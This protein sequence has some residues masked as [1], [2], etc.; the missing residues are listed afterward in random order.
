MENISRQPYTVQLETAEVQREPLTHPKDTQL[1]K[2]G[3]RLENKFPNARGQSN[4]T[5]YLPTSLRPH[6]APAHQP[7]PPKKHLY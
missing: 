1:S 7:P 6:P 4:T 2:V 3:I 5:H